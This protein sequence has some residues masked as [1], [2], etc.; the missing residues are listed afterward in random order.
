MSSASVVVLNIDDSA[1]WTGAC[2]VLLPFGPPTIA[3]IISASM[4]LFVPFLIFTAAFFMHLYRIWTGENY[5]HTPAAA[6]G[7]SSSSKPR[8]LG[9]PH[10]QYAPAA[11]RMEPTSRFF[12]GGGGGF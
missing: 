10:F 11:F 7:S 3:P 5:Y 1:A 12:G 2:P 8:P 6:A 4:G 9:P